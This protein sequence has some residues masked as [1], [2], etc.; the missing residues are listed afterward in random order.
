RMS[1]TSSTHRRDQRRAGEEQQQDHLAECRI[2][3]LSIELEAAPHADNECGQRECIELDRFDA[4]R[5]GYRER[6]RAHDKGREHDRLKGRTLR[7]L[8]TATQ[9]TPDGDRT[10]QAGQS[11]DESVRNANAEVSRD[12]TRHWF[13]RWSDQV[14][15]TVEDQQD[16]DGEPKRALI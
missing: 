7:V 13:N 6:D 15:E 2:V 12:P 9:L 10:A 5:A 8:Q 4:E 16:T 14:V 1:N 11:T 3:E